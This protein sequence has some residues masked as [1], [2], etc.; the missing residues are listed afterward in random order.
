MDIKEYISSGIIELYVM[1]LCSP[2]EEKELEQLRRHHPELQ[3]AIL[4]YETEMENKMLR[5]GTL[6]PVH[7]DEKILHAID[8]LQAPVIDISD[9]HSSFRKLNPVV[10]AKFTCSEYRRPY[11]TAFRLHC[12]YRP[13]H[14]PGGHVW[15]GQP[16]HL[17]LHHVLG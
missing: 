7:V 10:T 5:D 8:S 6:P 4:L 9:G 3:E 15:G 16:F 14:N 17:P 2:E 13:N 1:G 12:I 11:P